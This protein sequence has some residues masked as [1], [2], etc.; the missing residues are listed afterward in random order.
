MIAG[1]SGA[2]FIEAMADRLDGQN[3]AGGRRF[4]LMRSLAAQFPVFQTERRNVE[5]EVL[6]E[7]LK[8][9]NA[10]RMTL[11]ADTEL[12]FA[13]LDPYEAGCSNFLAAP[14]NPAAP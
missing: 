14:F 11:G 5:A 12:T 1:E 9:T 10:Y 4:A 3:R 13:S 6:T 7:F 2:R 8:R